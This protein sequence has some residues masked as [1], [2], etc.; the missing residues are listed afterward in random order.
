[1]NLSPSRTSVPRAGAGRFERAAVADRDNRRRRQPVLQQAIQRYFRRFI[2][3]CR[4][5]V[6]KQKLRRVQQRVRDAEALL[7]SVRHSA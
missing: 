1:L 4:G 7:L 6:E 5:L 2:Q 3:R